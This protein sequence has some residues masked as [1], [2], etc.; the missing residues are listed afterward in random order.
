[1]EFLTYKKRLDKE[2]VEELIQIFK[3]NNIE[4]EIAEEKASLDSLY[5]DQQFND[6]LLVKIRKIDFEKA[7]SLLLKTSETQLATVDKDHYLYTFTNDELFDII[8]KPDEW[9]EFDILLSQQILKERGTEINKTTIDLL[10]SQR[11]NTLA[12]PIEEPRAWIYAGYTFALLGGLI[13]IFM[14][15]SLMTA[16]KVLPNGEKIF[17]YSVNDRNHGTIIFFIG[18]IML[19]VVS[20]IRIRTMDF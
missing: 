13:G 10:R 17:T 12:K 20:I 15:L 18:I 8:S 6:Q 14:G 2:G 5:G 3:D 4:Y 1:M 7:D 16:K 19:I 11:I 9:N